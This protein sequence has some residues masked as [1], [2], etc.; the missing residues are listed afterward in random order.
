VVAI[1]R[2]GEGT[3]IAF[4]RYVP[5]KAGRG[6]SLDAMRRDDVGP[7]GVNERLI[8]EA[9]EW[10]RVHG[11]EDVSLNFAVFKAL[12]DGEGSRSPIEVLQGW[13]IKR[14]NPH[15]Q[16]ESLYTFNAK[17][18]PRWV[19]RHVAYRSRGDLAPVGI[20]YASAEAFLPFDRRRSEPPA[21]E[22]V[23]VPA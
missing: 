1:A 5:C 11:V 21:P 13:V 3:P 10:A 8:V 18:R 22:P 20:A 14:F 4:Q 19:P 17:F 9:V 15:F 16:L 7:N 23:A 2:D 6:L 12:L